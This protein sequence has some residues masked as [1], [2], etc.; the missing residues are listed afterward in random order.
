MLVSAVVGDGIDIRFNGSTSTYW[1]VYVTTQAGPTASASSSS[2]FNLGVGGTGTNQMS[3]VNI[4]DY[5]AA[6]QKLILAELGVAS[7]FNI[8]RM[9]RWDG[10]ATV[11]SITITGTLNA[12]STFALYGVS[13]V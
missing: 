10:T 9:G 7:N 3:V 5:T 2:S 1:N 12:G 6:T 13:S 4:F 8:F 11:T